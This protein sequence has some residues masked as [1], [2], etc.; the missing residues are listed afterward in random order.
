MS[1]SNLSRHRLALTHP[2]HHH[3]IQFLCHNHHHVFSC[4]ILI[5]FITSKKQII[6][7]NQFND[8]KSSYLVCFVPESWQ[9]QLWRVHLQVWQMK[10]NHYKRTFSPFFPS[11]ICIFP[12]FY[13]FFL[14]LSFKFF[15]SRA[16]NPV[17]R[18]ISAPLQLDI[19]CEVLLI[20]ILASILQNIAMAFKLRI[21]KI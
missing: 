18:G 16:T 17:G 1:T 6:K 13:Q 14:L 12:F 10:K 19:K 7:F 20:T 2:F 9:K 11:N 21:V 15:S 8:S 4:P 5:I 3:H